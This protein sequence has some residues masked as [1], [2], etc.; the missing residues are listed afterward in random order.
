MK[1]RK[2]FIIGLILVG[3]TG[4]SSI[5]PEECKV[6]DS[7]MWFDRGYNDAL[8]GFKTTK[9]A[10]YAQVC[11]EVGVKA[12]RDAWDLGY[13]K[14]LDLYCTPQTAYMMGAA[15]SQMSNICPKSSQQALLNAHYL[16]SEK[17][18]LEQETQHFRAEYERL[19]KEYR[20][21][22]R[23]DRLGFQSEVEARHYYNLL[24]Y[25]IRLART[26]YEQ[27]LYRLRMMQ[28]N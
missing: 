17:R 7:K 20:Q 13:N 23:G 18:Q 5:S 11:A 27:S 14:G 19:R 3:M 21:M 26:N 8:A 15:G 16:G 25:H 6:A 12:D 1:V 2:T 4:C 22:Q 10:D 24:P 28:V 9:F